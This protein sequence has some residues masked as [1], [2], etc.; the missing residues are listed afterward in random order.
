MLVI[1]GS[2]GEG[3]GQVLRSSLTLSLLTQRP[4]RIERIRG[5]RRTPG[6]LRQHLTAVEAA[7]RI[8]DAEV[9]GAELGAVTL[10]F[11]PRALRA[12][13]Y[14]LSIGSAGSASLVVQTVLPALLAAD[15]ASE[16]V[17]EGGTHNGKSPPFEFLA[18]V[19]FP[20]LR[21]MGA[22]VRGTLVRSGFYPAGGGC[23]R[24]AVGVGGG[25]GRTLQPPPL[26]ERLEAPQLA[27]RAVYARLPVHVAERELSLVRR[28]L[29]LAAAACR[30]VEVRSRGPGNALQ[31]A[32]AQEGH[33]VVEVVTAFG[34]RRK[35]AE[36]VAAEAVAELRRYLEAGV[37]VGE[38]LADQLL[39]P[40]AM[41]GGGSFLTQTPSLHAT[42]NA[43]IVETFLPRTVRI[44]PVDERVSRVTVM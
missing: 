37:C 22:D 10:S 6:L 11:R 5:N 43:A 33:G 27:A 39:I 16:V 25:G 1:D 24:V 7:T 41:A 30:A 14:E 23:L 17:V 3:G 40:L 42:T 36:D 31:I 44:E 15:G 29:G 21:K 4:F 12:G 26:P 28:E 9:E 20:I 18:D 13:R 19:F 38:H 35:P 2:Q 8:G 32:V 34:E